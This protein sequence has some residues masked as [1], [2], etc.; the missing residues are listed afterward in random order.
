MPTEMN[1][2]R[3]NS[4]LI[5]PSQPVAGVEIEAAGGKE[6]EADT[7]EQEIEHCS[8]PQSVARLNL[9][10]QSGTVMP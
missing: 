2:P 9:A 1:P 5:S 3:I 6:A 7:K 10:G 4:K 8:N